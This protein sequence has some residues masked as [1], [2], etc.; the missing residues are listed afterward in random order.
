MVEVG[1]REEGE[2]DLFKASLNGEGEVVFLA[3][4]EY[5][6]MV[7]ADAAY[8]PK[9]NIY[10]LHRGCQPSPPA[11][12]PRPPDRLLF[13]GCTPQARQKTKDN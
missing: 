1:R 9:A 2:G 6:V 8:S 7:S 5:M 10:K 3:S 11:M 13:L 12:P 4:L